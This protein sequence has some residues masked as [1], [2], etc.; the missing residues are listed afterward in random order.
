MATNPALPRGPGQIE[1]L[2]REARGSLL[3]KRKGEARTVLGQL[4]H[5]SS[6]AE[7]I[8]NLAN[9]VSSVTEEVARYE[10]SRGDVRQRLLDGGLLT[11]IQQELDE[12]V[13]YWRAFAPDIPSLQSARDGLPPSEDPAFRSRIDRLEKMLEE[14]QVAA[15]THEWH[16]LGMP[17]GT[18]STGFVQSIGYLQQLESLV[19]S[20]N[21][22]EAGRVIAE[23]SPFFESGDGVRFRTGMSP[24]VQRIS[25]I[26]G[27]ETLLKE[28][29]MALP[30]PSAHEKE[31]LALSLYA[32]SDAVKRRLVY[33]SDLGL[34][35]MSRRLQET[36][37]SVE[38]SETPVIRQSTGAGWIIGTLIMLLLLIVGLWLWL[39][40]RPEA[41]TDSPAAPVSNQNLR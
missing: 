11:S 40:V 3:A 21:W 18:A 36:L 39:Q 32:A 8:G 41:F 22:T 13:P 24:I 20:E 37:L 19:D 6:S 14:G 23:C 12:E 4:V 5:L 38:R 27:W 15:A 29:S 16:Q 30:N 2:R 31:R 9:L 7:D 10:R 17:S 25:E 33:D 34:K 28:C 1:S 26:V 35:E